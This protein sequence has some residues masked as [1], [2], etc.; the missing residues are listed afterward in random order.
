M[1]TAGKTWE[2]TPTG[3]E[4]LG[5]EK[6]EGAIKRL[7][8]THD[9]LVDF[10]I[11]NPTVSQRQIA[12]QFGFTETWVSRMICSDAF[13]ARL[14]VRKNE[15]VD[16]IILQS[17]EEKLRGLVDLSATV[18]AEK[19]E[20]NRNP[21]LAVKV[22]GLGVT[23]LGYGAREKNIQ[24]QNNFVVMLPEKAADSEDWANRARPQ[25]RGVAAEVVDAVEV[26]PAPGKNSDPA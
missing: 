9:S 17:V 23:A 22:L 8:F 24:T 21:D 4:G 7:R 3:P 19:L 26:A 13:Q 1:S 20:A 15:L 6:A 11:A 10:I 14:A 5:T 2:V 16:P 18:I 12:V 25:P